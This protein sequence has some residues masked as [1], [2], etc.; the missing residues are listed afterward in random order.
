[1][2]GFIEVNREY[3]VQV[4]GIAV[5]HT[6]EPVFETRTRKVAISILQIIDFD[7]KMICTTKILNCPHTQTNYSEAVSIKESYEEIKDLIQRATNI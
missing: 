5:Q 1:M 4:R 3:K 6:N 7:D 2:K